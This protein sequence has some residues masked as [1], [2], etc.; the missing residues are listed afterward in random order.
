MGLDGC[1]ACDPV[2][3]AVPEGWR[4]LLHS[5]TVSMA[6]ISLLAF[7]L[8]FSIW[9]TWRA[10]T[11]ILSPI[12]EMIWLRCA[13]NISFC[14]FAVMIILIGAKWIQPCARGM[15]VLG[16]VMAGIGLWELIESLVSY[17][18]GILVGEL[19][20]YSIMLF[21]C[22]LIVFLLYRLKGINIID[23]S[24]LSPV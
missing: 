7:F 9:N 2:A 11:Y 12:P 3:D 5:S 1:K 22:S 14:L 10:V 16:N 20:A 24:L 13:L 18:T 17:S 4:Y 8:T 21:T 19:I 15:K 23:S 6:G